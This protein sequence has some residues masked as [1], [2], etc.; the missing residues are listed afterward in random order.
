[1]RKLETQDHA[2]TISAKLEAMSAEMA[3]LRNPKD[4][5]LALKQQATLARLEQ[6]GVDNHDHLCQEQS[7]FSS[8]ISSVRGELDALRADAVADSKRAAEEQIRTREVL[9]SLLRDSITGLESAHNGLKQEIMR[10][11]D[12]S[13]TVMMEELID[14]IR[15]AMSQAGHATEGCLGWRDYVGK[16][17]F[18]CTQLLRT[19]IQQACDHADC[20]M[21]LD[22]LIQASP[23]CISLAT[24]GHRAAVQIGFAQL[25]FLLECR[26][27]ACT[28]F[29]R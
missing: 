28:P 20:D 27:V 24:S 12:K 11:L 6:L 10:G 7:R 14:L 4:S 29:L 9:A 3:E 23:P 26:S 22:G 21:L 8:Q 25:M 15:E 5:A 1:V 13:L 18:C 2:A 17:H 16:L 19:L